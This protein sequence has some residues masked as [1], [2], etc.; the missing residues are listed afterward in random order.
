AALLPFEPDGSIAVEGFQK[1]LRATHEAGLTN[2]VNMDT[3]YVDYLTE[4]ERLQ[5]LHWTREALWARASPSSPALTSKG[6]TATLFLFIAARWIRSL[7]AA[8]RPSSFRLRGSTVENYARRLL[9]TKRH[10]GVI[11]RFLVS[12]SLRCLRQTV[13]FST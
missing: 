3:G 4:A 10:V 13:R 11:R 7:L 8:A 2:A 12:N 5:V 9:P 6:W 1:H